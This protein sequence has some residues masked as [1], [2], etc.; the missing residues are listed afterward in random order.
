MLN[1]KILFSIEQLYFS[2][3][4]EILTKRDWKLELL[5]F[6]TVPLGIYKNQISNLLQ[7]RQHLGGCCIVLYVSNSPANV[8][9][10]LLSLERFPLPVASSNKMNKEKSTVWI[11]LV[12][13]IPDCWSKLEKHP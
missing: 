12:L 11:S 3:F 6:L 5:S 2:G 8:E 9:P 10:L 4:T 13:M 1:S 7:H